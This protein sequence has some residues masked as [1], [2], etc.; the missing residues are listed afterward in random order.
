MTDYDLW[1]AI[2]NV[3]QPRLGAVQETKL[4]NN[5]VDS[6]SQT[7]HKPWSE[8]LMHDSS[9]LGNKPMTLTFLLST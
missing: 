6:W 2:N 4:K 8:S 5:S 3:K 7:G 9:Y 1:T